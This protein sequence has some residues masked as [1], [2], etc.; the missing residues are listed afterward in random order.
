MPDGAAR[1]VQGMIEANGVDFTIALKAPADFLNSQREQPSCI[2]P[3]RFAINF[4]AV[5]CRRA[6]LSCN[7]DVLVSRLTPLIRLSASTKSVFTTSAV[8]PFPP[9]D[10]ASM[11]A[12][13]SSGIVTATAVFL[14]F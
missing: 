14:P 4:G 11:R 1:A 6:S 10:G 2:T 7:I 13:R 3:R 5:R 8:R 12:I 9:S